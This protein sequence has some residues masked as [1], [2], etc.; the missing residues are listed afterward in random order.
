MPPGSSESSDSGVGE[1]R[2]RLLEDGETIPSNHSTIPKED[3]AVVTGDVKPYPS[4]LSNFAQ[5]LPTTNSLGKS[6]L[7]RKGPP[8]ATKLKSLRKR[9]IPVVTLDS[10][11]ESSSEE[12]K[13]IRYF[14]VCLSFSRSVSYLFLF[15][16]LC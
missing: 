8:D 6:G 3:S 13:Q 2:R 14:W 5:R 10:S 11:E 12:E 7:K 4:G 9:E 16:Y 1:T 15:L